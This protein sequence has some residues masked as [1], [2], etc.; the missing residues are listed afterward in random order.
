MGSKAS[1][2]WVLALSV[3]CAGLS[4][5]QGGQVVHTLSPYSSA[6]SAG[7][8]QFAIEDFDGDHKPDIAEVQIGQTDSH[9]THYSIRVR[10][11]TG[12]KQSIGLD[13]SFGGLSIVPRD[14][15]G[16]NALDLI[17]STALLHK[18]VAILLNDGYGNFSQA[19]PSSFP[20]AFNESDTYL[21]P[22]L[23]RVRDVAGVPPQPNSGFFLQADGLPNFQRRA[24]P[25][26]VLCP[27]FPPS[28]FCIS[29]AG[30]APP[31]HV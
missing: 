21:R 29:Q 20:G 25:I 28:A 22:A 1:C 24:G 11:T 18:P 7:A 3:L 10:L 17:V 16:D 27:G 23:A 26:S 15:N 6:F 19:E 14:V 13:A 31:S 30:R 5:G 8:H 2:R 9:S 12:T 4:L